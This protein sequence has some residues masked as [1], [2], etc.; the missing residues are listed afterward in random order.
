V[1]VLGALLYHLVERPAQ[2]WIGRIADRRREL[3]IDAVEG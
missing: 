3:S 1:L 2:H